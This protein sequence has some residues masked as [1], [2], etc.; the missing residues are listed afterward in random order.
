ME[1][2]ERLHRNL[3]DK[4]LTICTLVCSLREAN[5]EVDYKVAS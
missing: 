5:I 2:N 1:L 3:A 4:D